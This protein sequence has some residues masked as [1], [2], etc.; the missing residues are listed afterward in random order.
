MISW[1]VAPGGTGQLVLVDDDEVP[2]VEGQPDAHRPLARHE[3][4]AGDH[5]GLGRAVGVP[6][7]ALGRREAG[8]EL[9]RAGLTAEDE[10]P[11]RLEGLGRPQRREGGHRRDDG[12]ALRDEP[13]A[14]VHAGAHERSRRRHEAGAVRPGEPHLLARG[15]E[16]DRE[17]GEHAVAGADPALP[18]E[19][20]RL[21]IDEGSSR[22][23]GDGDALGH[24]RRAGREDDPGVVGRPDGGE[25][26]VGAA[27]PSGGRARGRR[28]VGTAY[29]SVGCVGAE[30][31]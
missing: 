28:D 12:D 27:V 18:Q 16:G 7:L 25:R 21:R 26:L 10:Q 15:V 5:R 1:P 24:P 11:H 2:A 30:C 6:H 22:P 14:E 31:A 20:P 3:R 4:A 29:G 17:P 13:R 8:D 23:V 9:G 19:D